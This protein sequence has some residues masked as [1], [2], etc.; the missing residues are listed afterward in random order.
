MKYF[1]FYD[2]RYL[3]PMTSHTMGELVGR[4][5]L[6]VSFDQKPGMGRG[7]GKKAAATRLGRLFAEKLWRKP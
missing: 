5:P 4:K 1:L 3:R 2:D 6:V 7:N